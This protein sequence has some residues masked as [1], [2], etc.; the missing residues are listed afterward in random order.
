V[1]GGQEAKIFARKAAPILAF[2]MPVTK[3]GASSWLAGARAAWHLQ[4]SDA[5]RRLADAFREELTA[6]AKADP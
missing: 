5:G 4:L 6:D 3:P 2:S 1:F